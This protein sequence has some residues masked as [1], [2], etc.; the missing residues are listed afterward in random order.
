MTPQARVQAGI[1]ILDLVIAAAKGGGASADRI[2]ADWFKTRRFAGSKDRRAVRELVYGAIRACGDVP[3][4]GRAAILRLAETEV[5]IHV[6]FDGQG[7][8]P[9]P[10][11]PDEPVAAAG[12]APAWL[13]AE[14]A[15]SGIAG[16]EANALLGRAPLDI[17]VNTLKA[18]RGS[19]ELPERGEPLAAP[20]ALRLPSGSA[21]EQ[22]H[23]YQNGLI[24][25]QD[26]GS[27]IACLAVAAQPGE[28]VIDL[29]AGAGGKTLALAAA[30]ENRGRLI[31]CDT[32][33]NRLSRLAPRAERAGARLIGV[34]LLNPGQEA[35]AL[36]DLAGRVDA[37][38]VDA[39]CSGTGTW[40][41]NPE[42]RWRLSP[43]E[44]V[45]YAAIQAR[46]LDLA[47]TLVRPGGRVTFVTCSLL[48]AEGADQAENFLTSHP[49]WRAEL[50][51]LPAG[52]ARGQGWRL[53][54]RAD[55]TDG[56]FI[57]CFVSP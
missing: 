20:Q 3:V 6:L 27:Q 38:L 46:L 44:I 43:Q 19:I 12:I 33:R 49:G 24:E 56:F 5:A 47:A 31:A 51:H 18:D 30:M 34:R 8:G 2:V 55:Q 45:R 28:T 41:R 57:A 39:P 48:D 11:L 23:A 7:H 52:T 29:C 13:E 40:R 32:D 1:E 50:P 25:V 36:D 4:S 14:L 42:A 15:A 22:W 17:R 9:A 37:V 10:V 16:D 26:G 53:S 54:P 35:A 21:V